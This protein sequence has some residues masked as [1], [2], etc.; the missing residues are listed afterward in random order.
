MNPPSAGSVGC[1]ALIRLEWRGVIPRKQRFAALACQ[2]AGRF[3]P[4]FAVVVASDT[5]F[6]W[7][8]QNQPD[9][10]LPLLSDLPAD[11]RGYS[12]SAQVLKERAYRLDGLYLPPSERSDLPALILQAQMAADSGF[13]RRLYA[14][15]TRL[16]QQKLAISHWRVVVLCP[17]AA[18]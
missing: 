8:F 12:F 11:A 14:E 16:V 13:L 5:L 3:R 10:I 17:L 6:Y 1:G 15:T 7:L 18:N 2:P 9:R 4:G